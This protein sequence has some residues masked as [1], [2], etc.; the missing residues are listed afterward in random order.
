VGVLN[1]AIGCL[2]TL[3]GAGVLLLILFMGVGQ[4]KTSEW[5]LTG[6]LFTAGG[7]LAVAGLSLCRGGRIHGKT[8]ALVAG[9][10][11]LA[12]VEFAVIWVMLQSTDKSSI[13]FP[14]G[15]ILLAAVQLAW[16]LRTWQR[17]RDAL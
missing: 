12:S 16:V 9:A 11:A 8:V 5:C 14:T 7:L 1:L 17:D 3:F 15:F 4:T 13:F 6:S 2:G 10:V